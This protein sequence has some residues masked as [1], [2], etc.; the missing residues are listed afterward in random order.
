MADNAKND[1]D[2][3]IWKAIYD[4]GNEIKDLREDIENIESKVK[5]IKESDKVKTKIKNINDN[6]T[7]FINNFD[8]YSNE[9]RIKFLE[10]FNKS[11]LHLIRIS[12]C[13]LLFYVI[14]FRI[15]SYCIF[16]RKGF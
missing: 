4:L 14:L 10:N 6:Y 2:L 12:G 7:A 1:E 9:D 3:R 13:I 5:S 11:L 8:K 15:R 16:F